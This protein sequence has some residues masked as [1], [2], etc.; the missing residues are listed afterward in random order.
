MAGLADIIITTEIVMKTIVKLS[1][2][3]F[4]TES[5]RNK[6][7]KIKASDIQEKVKT[8][9]VRRYF[10]LFVIHSMRFLLVL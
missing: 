5:E 4:S 6:A 3:V 2:T 9:M 8:D 7:A 1:T 10:S